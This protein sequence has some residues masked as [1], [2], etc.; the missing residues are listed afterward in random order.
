MCW[1]FEGRFLA[2]VDRG[3]VT[4]DDSPCPRLHCPRGRQPAPPGGRLPGP[5]PLWKDLLQPGKGVQYRR[6]AFVPL[7]LPCRACPEHEK[8]GKERRVYCFSTNLLA[9]WRLL[10][11]ACSPVMCVDVCGR[12]VY[13]LRGTACRAWKHI[14]GW[15]S[16]LARDAV[17][18]WSAQ[19]LM[20]TPGECGQAMD[21][22][23]VSKFSG[24]DL[25]HS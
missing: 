18:A 11:L 4:D 16:I 15:I 13:C 10:H 24:N 14:P 22:H 7:I 17:Q 19:M 5:R 6:T 12:C 2:R 1:R 3:G 25:M 21:T 23:V 9:V 8:E 20:E